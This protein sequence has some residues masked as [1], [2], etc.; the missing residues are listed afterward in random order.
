MSTR[1]VERSRRAQKTTHREK[2]VAHALATST[3]EAAAKFN[4]PESTLRRWVA[5][6]K[7]AGFRLPT[8]IE[9]ATLEVAHARARR[10]RDEALSSVTD[11]LK[12]LV[13][14]ATKSA[15]AEFEKTGK[16]PGK[17]IFEVAGAAK[18]LGELDMA[19][20]VLLAPGDKIDASDASDADDTAV[21][22]TTSSTAKKSSAS[23]EHDP[24][25]DRVVESPAG[26]SQEDDWH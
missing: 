8:P 14:L 11:D 21:S 20:R 4:V 2:A 13:R 12:K 6:A 1:S 23:R 19:E 10:V 18:I 24:V 15:E 17:V 5:Q 16:V 9:K 7:A 25:E 26:P 3:A 22:R